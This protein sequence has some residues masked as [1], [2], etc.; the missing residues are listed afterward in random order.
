MPVQTL[1]SLWAEPR[2]P[3]PPGPAERDW[4][5]VGA[6]IT[7]AT[8]E[9]LVRPDLAWRPLSLAVVVLAALTLPWRRVHPFPVVAIAFGTISVLDLVAF[10]RG[11]EWEGLGSGIFLLLLLFTLARWGSGREVVAGL[12]VLAIPLTLT[13]LRGAPVGDVVGGVL[14]VLLAA[15]LGGGA[16]Y[17]GASRRQELSA[18]RSR[19][20]EQ[21]AR[22]LHDTVAHHVSAITIQAQAGRALAAT[23]P[24][25]AVE[26]LAVIEEEASRALEEMR[27]MVGALRQGEADLTPQQGVHDI[28]RLARGDGRAPRVEVELRG[29]LDGLRAAVDAALYRLAQE[30]VTNALRHSREATVVRVQVDGGEDVVGLR[31]D[32]DGLPVGGAATP[33]GFGLVGMAERVEL[34][35]GTFAAGPRTDRGWSVRAELP[36]RGA[37]G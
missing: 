35:G 19:E 5:L 9:T 2:A 8:I 33:G 30:S 10:A 36:R 12:A 11:V 24:S 13:A 22:E 26:A 1:R 28:A 27:T 4:L 21:L 20:R 31:V 18:L 32:D 29:D 17:L 25:V 6:W 16:R 7:A 15:A 3:D 34:L 23:R 14:V 37:S